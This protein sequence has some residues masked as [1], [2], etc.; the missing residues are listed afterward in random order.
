MEFDGDPIA[1]AT[2]LQVCAVAAAASSASAEPEPE[3]V[4]DERPE[5]VMQDLDA[6]LDGLSGVE[7]VL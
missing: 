4:Q 7:N 3:P 2:N 1:L 6:I 5:P